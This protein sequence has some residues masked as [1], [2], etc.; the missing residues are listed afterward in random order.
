V[1]TFIGMAVDARTRKPILGTVL[2]GLSGPAIKPLALAKLWETVQ[3]VDIPVI[4]M[5]GIA[6][7]IDAV[8]FLLTGATAIEVGTALF[9]NPGL[10]EDCVDAIEEAV[11]QAQASTVDD[12]IG[13]LEVPEGRGVIRAGR[14]ARREAGRHAS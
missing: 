10:P 14:T 3:A 7:P 2:G 8:E 1:N 6:R 4:G 11:V 13:A 12:L 5:G 9:A